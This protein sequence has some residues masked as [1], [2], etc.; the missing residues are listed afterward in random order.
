MVVLVVGAGPAGLEAARI[1]RER[2]HDVRLIER[3]DRIGGQLDLWSRLPG[4]EHLATMI[5][6]YERRFRK[7]GLEPELGVEVG[8]EQVRAANPNVL[9][10]ATGARYEPTGE[11]GF[12][13]AEI[14]GWD[15]PHVHTPEAVIAGEVSL[16]GRVVIV[17]DEGL[18]TAAGVAEIAAQTATDVCLV[19]RKESPVAHLGTH[20][21]YALPRLVA[22][23][24]RILAHRWVTEIGPDRVRLVDLTYRTE[25][26]IEAVDEVV[27]A[28]MRQ[29]VDVL[30]AV[31]REIPYAYVVGDALSPRGLREATYEGYR[32]GRVIG[33]ADMPRTV[34]DELWDAPMPVLRPAAE[35]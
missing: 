8:E 35:V 31:A 26:T 17:D 21:A 14:P 12:T 27:L 29:P 16:V 24:V 13:R 7:L 30:S 6:W 11:S 22:A 20:R 9:V 28:T 5:G 34:T 15:R 23:G 10:V 19:S 18:H 2:G 32:F 1:A 3:R 25:E 4:R 33:E